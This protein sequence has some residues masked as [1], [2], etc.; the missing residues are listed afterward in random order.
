MSADKY[1]FVSPGVF[2]T[3]V[4]QSQVTTPGTN[5]DGPVIIGRATQGPSFKPTRVHSYSEFVQIFGDTVA[6]GQA[7]DVWRNGNFTTPMYGTYAAKAYLANNNPI[8]YVRLLGAQDANASST[9]PAAGAA[10]W[11]VGNL[12]G[13]GQNGAYGLFVTPDPVEIAA[14]ASIFVTSSYNNA[15]FASASLQVTGAFAVN[16]VASGSVFSLLDSAGA[17]KEFVIDSMT[18]SSAASIRTIGLLGT[19][20]A[21]GSNYHQAIAE[22]FAN[23]INNSNNDSLNFTATA[24][25]SQGHFVIRQQVNGTDGNQTNVYGTLKGLRSTNFNF[26]GGEDMLLASGSTFSLVNFEGV[27]K[28]FN[29]DPHITASSAPVGA[30][31]TLGTSSMQQLAESFV[32][33]FNN[34]SNQNASPGFTAASASAGIVL[35]AVSGGASGNRTNAMGTLTDVILSNFT[36]GAQESAVSGKLGAIFYCNGAAPVLSGTAPSGAGMLSNGALLKQVASGPEFKIAISGSNS[37]NQ[38][39][40][41]NFSPNSS[42]FIRKVFNTNPVKTN[43]YTQASSAKENYWLGETYEKEVAKLGTGNCQA[44]ILGLVS[45]AAQLGDFYGLSTA[46]KGPQASATGWFIAQDTNTPSSDFNPTSSVTQLFKLHGLTANG[47]ET[48]SRVKVTIR[49]IRMPSAQEQSVDPYPS[50]TVQLR[51][52][53]DTDLRPVVLETFSNCNLNPN[54]QNYICRLIGDKYE[55]FNSTTSRLDE[56][57]DYDNVS[58]YVRVQVN[59]DIRAG[60]ETPALAPFGVLGPLKFKTVVATSGSAL[61][62]DSATALTASGIFSA[63]GLVHGTTGANQIF[64]RDSSTVSLAFPSVSLIAS[65]S[66]MGYDK[67]RDAYFGVNLLTEGSTNRFDESTLDLLRSKPGD[68]DSFTA[69]NATDHQYAFTLDNIVISDSV[70]NA[71]KD[72]VT[73]TT[74][75]WHEAGARGTAAGERSS[76]TALSGAA[77][78]VNDRRINKFTTVMFGGN[79]GLDITEGDPFRNTILDDTNGSAGGKTDLTNYALASINRAINIISDAETTEF[80]LAAIPGI[81]VPAVTNKLVEKCE[82]RGDALA[83]IDVEHDYI[84]VHEGDGSNSYPILPDITQAVSKMRSRTTDSSYGCAFYPFV[85]T[86]DVPSGQMLW[87]PPSVVGLGTLGSSAATSEL[88]F[89]PAG[90]NRGGLSQGA[91][92]LTVTNVRRKLTSQQR[93]DLYD[94]RINPIASFPTEGIVVFGQKTLQLQR[95]ALDRINVR[96]LMIFLKKKISQIANTILFD[97]NVHSTWNRFK[98]QAIPLLEDVQA[99]FGLEDFKLI[100]DETTTTPDLRDRNVMYAKVFL[101][102]AKAI[103]FIAIDFFIT[104]SGAS[105]ED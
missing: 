53:R 77:A 87:V 58:K 79:D 12:A 24:S 99:R 54:S 69:G 39:K 42:K 81:T 2:I 50:F 4:D 57:G 90:F 64:M 38:F 83:V 17:A 34:T 71:Y 70:G 67:H 35:T 61:A 13:N 9:D 1:R 52:L 86:R 55:E 21:S 45:G 41:F 6:G 56:Y 18:T 16:L 65:S 104:N 68:I 88:W 63:G 80:D 31:G 59:D 36:G 62:T 30:I 33:S 93:D 101:K 74:T 97:Q 43:T 26:V 76:Y 91:G 82:E 25:V 102:P 22:A 85:Q 100:L 44:V 60:Q 32:N 23:S 95:S 3:E 75:A 84:P 66:D 73:E 14:S 48:Q 5:D 29:I 92:G 72:S 49:D 37:K 20:S 19:G 47:A 40:T 105:F 28:T 103:E 11:G 98:G 10:G 94:V 8:T 96:R 46:D 7:G 15:I 51:H 27:T 89:A 78:L